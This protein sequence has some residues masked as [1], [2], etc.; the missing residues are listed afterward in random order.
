MIWC[1]TRSEVL[2]PIVHTG[3]YVELVQVA[4]LALCLHEI[5]LPFFYHRMQQAL[6]HLW[7]QQLWL[8]GLKSDSVFESLPNGN[9]NVNITRLSMSQNE[10][11]QNSVCAGHSVNI[12]GGSPGYESL[13]LTYTGRRLDWTTKKRLLVEWLPYLVWLEE[14]RTCD[15]GI[16]FGQ[17]ACHWMMAGV[18]GC[19]A[20]WE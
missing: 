12:F 6:A 18:G 9:L 13:N 19:H 14:A 17:P 16:P 15:M 4:N 1:N 3:I 11:V 10:A 2:A 7:D 5:Q 8:S 20:L